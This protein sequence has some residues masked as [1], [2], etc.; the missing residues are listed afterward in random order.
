MH[1]N[2]YITA[3]KQDHSITRKPHQ[4]ISKP[5]KL[6]LCPNKRSRKGGEQKAI[7]EAT[8]AT[9]FTPRGLIA[10]KP[11]TKTTQ[12]ARTK[13][14]E[15]TKREREKNGLHSVFTLSSSLFLPTK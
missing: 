12:R 14:A 6:P 3:S 10:S 13:G 9:A 5:H 11:T 2:I 8:M 15:R 4:I 7:Y 1:H